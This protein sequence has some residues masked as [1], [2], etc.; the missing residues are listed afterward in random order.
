MRAS[1]EA[2][3]GP[4]RQAAEEAIASAAGYPELAEEVKTVESH[5]TSRPQLELFANLKKQKRVRAVDTV[6]ASLRAADKALTEAGRTA[7]PPSTP[8]LLG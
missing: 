5:L 3:I 6:R 8:S 1:I 7:R 2:A 4:A